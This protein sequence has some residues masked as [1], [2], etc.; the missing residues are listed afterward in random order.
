MN[1]CGNSDE[2]LLIGGRGFRS[3][4]INRSDHLKS[5]LEL[6]AGTSNECCTL[7]TEHIFAR[8]ACWDSQFYHSDEFAPHR[9]NRFAQLSTMNLISMGRDCISDKRNFLIPWHGI[10]L[11]S[12][13]DGLWH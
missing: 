9:L 13:L 5:F 7:L 11:G 4:G 2:E 12:A 3:K 1:R 8:F 6:T 10:V